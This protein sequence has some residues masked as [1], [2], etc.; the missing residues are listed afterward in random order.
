M[1]TSTNTADAN[2]VGSTGGSAS[3]FLTAEQ[4][5]IGSWWKIAQGGEYGYCVTAVDVA[6]RE[7]TVLSTKGEVREIDTFKL[8][9]R[10]S[11]VLPNIVHE[12]HREDGREH[13]KKA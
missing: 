5:S 8:Q 4:I 11:R 1:K 12:P 10:Y 3:D 6:R 9:C 7:A 2:R 13:A